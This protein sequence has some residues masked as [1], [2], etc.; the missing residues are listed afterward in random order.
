[1]EFL[2]FLESQDLKGST[3]EDAM[4]K[5]V[6]SAAIELTDEQRMLLAKEFNIPGLGLGTSRMGYGGE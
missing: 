3:T 1:M 2:R 4:K 6:A 5:L